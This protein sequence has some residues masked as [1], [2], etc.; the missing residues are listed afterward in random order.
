MEHI[1]VRNKEDIF[2]A[3]LKELAGLDF[4]FLFLKYPERTIYVTDENSFGNKKVI[5][6]I[7]Q[8]DF[9]RYSKDNSKEIYNVS[10]TKCDNI[11]Q[12]EEVE[13]LLKSKKRM[14]AIPVLNEKGEVE[15]EYYKVINDS[16]EKL[17]LIEGIAEESKFSFYEKNVFI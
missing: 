3:D 13:E 1:Y 11:C 7:T 10:F 16:E 9:L 15:K 17:R 4:E 5:G 2:L 14:W 12:A 8:G 6:I